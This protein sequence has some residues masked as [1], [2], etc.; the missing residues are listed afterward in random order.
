MSRP[1][2]SSEPIILPVQCAA[3]RALAGLSQ[4]E[5]AERVPCALGTI[6]RFENG[7]ISPL[8]RTLREIVAALETAG[9]TMIID[10]ASIGVR[11]RNPAD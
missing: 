2:P 1:P 8:P 9:V 3:A 5:L 6:S 7:Q 10:D 11:L 4:K